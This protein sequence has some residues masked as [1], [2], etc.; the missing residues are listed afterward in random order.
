MST[1]TRNKSYKD[2]KA[3]GGFAA[4]DAEVLDAVRASGETGITRQEISATRTRA[5]NSVCGAV[6]RLLAEG[7]IVEVGS[8][9][10]PTSGK[11]NAILVV[12]R[13]EVG[14]A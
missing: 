10:N 4:L 3:G 8:R 2:M 11:Q 7:A 12:Y 9:K 1:V 5:I 14:A 13:R 6:A